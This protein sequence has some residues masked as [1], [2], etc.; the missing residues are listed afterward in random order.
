VIQTSLALCQVTG[1]C[2]LG[3]WLNNEYPSDK[4]KA[5]IDKVVFQRSTEEHQ[6][7]AVVTLQPVATVNEFYVGLDQ[8]DYSAGAKHGCFLTRTF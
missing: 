5:V 6:M 4:L 1:E 2:N 3:V 7:P 8:L